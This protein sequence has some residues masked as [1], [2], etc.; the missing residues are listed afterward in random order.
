MTPTGTVTL[1]D[2][3]RARDERQTCQRQLLAREPDATLIVF[4]PVAPGKEK[5]NRN[6]LIVASAAREALSRLF[7]DSALYWEEK[8][9]P[10]GFELWIMV[11]EIP[12][13]VKRQTTEIEETHPLGRLMDIDVIGRDAR[14]VSR[15]ELGLPSRRCLIC[16]DDAR[17]CMR[18]GRHSYSDLL[19]TISQMTDAYDAPH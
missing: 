10:T 17:I 8:D 5:R 3:L 16:G 12:E 6:T 7:V 14:P 19:R 4:T 11:P 2:M 15:T 18:A 1:E 9:L 13:T